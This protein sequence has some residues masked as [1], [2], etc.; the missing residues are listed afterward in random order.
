MN[1]LDFE[2]LENNL[3]TSSQFGSDTCIA[4][5][6]LLQEKYNTWLKIHNN[7]LFRYYY[8]DESNTGY[9]FP[10]PLKTSLDSDFWLK[11]ALDFI[12]Q[13]ATSKNRV[14]NFCFITDEQKQLLDESLSKNFNLN[15]SWK[16]NRNDSDYIYLQSNLAELP[17]SLYQKKRN[18]I[19]HFKRIYGNNWNFKIFPENDIAQDFLKVAQKWFEEKNDHENLALKQEQ[20]SISLALKN[21][22][23][24]KLKGGVL[25]VNKEPVAITLAS[26]I[27]NSVL[28]I[29]YEKAI[30]EY[31]KNGAY[32]VINQQFAIS[33]P[34][35]K[36]F[37]R[38]EDLGL[39]GLRKSKL[40][41][42]PDIILDKFF[43]TVID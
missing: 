40:S 18:H 21:A 16:S 3:D 27:S 10:L 34:T 32:A 8:G 30:G 6:F 33:N 15:I 26:P 42:K 7:V 25:Y 12:F 22:E 20:Q 39:S 2:Y 1:L 19:S 36:Y 14:I 5:L 24:L 13:D 4:N 35:Y 28:D 23:L 31:E 41:Y 43:G 38:E 11:T 17:G 9:G 29:I 37:N